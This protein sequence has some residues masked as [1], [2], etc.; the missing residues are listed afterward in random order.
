MSNYREV[1]SR[2]ERRGL[3]GVDPS[4][5]QSVV[6]DVDPVTRRQPRTRERSERR[7]TPT[8]PEGAIVVPGVAQDRGEA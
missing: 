8:P 5:S 1:R 7:S 6:V 3:V 2:S 4:G